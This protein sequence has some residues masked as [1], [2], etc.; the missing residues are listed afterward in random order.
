[1]DQDRLEFPQEL[2]PHVGLTSRE[3]GFMKKAGCPFYG[4]KTTLRW[5]RKFITHQ[6]GAGQPDP[7]LAEHPQN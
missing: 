1:M 5:V 7:S 4:R 2:A 3:I 6:A